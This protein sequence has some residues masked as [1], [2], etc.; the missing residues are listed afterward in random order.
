VGGA[1]W[2]DI[3]PAAHRLARSTILASDATASAWDRIAAAAPDA[4]ADASPPAAQGG[5]GGGACLPVHLWVADV[6]G[7]VCAWEG[8]GGIKDMKR[9]MPGVLYPSEP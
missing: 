9:R 6:P 1:W 3:N 5:A 2:S 8:V 7:T 4:P